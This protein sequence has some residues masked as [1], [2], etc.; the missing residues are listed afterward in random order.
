MKNYRYI[1]FLAVMALLASCREQL[2]TDDPTL[3]LRFSQDTVRF[4]TVFSST[5]GQEASA[6]LQ[7]M[8]YNDHREAIV[9]DRVWMEAGKEFSVNVDGESDLDRLTRLQ[10]NGGD[11]LF[12]FVRVG[13]A[14]QGQDGPLWHSDALHMHLSTGITQ[15]LYMEA[16]GQDVI[17]IRSTKGRS[18]FASYRFAADKPYLIYDTMVVGNLTIDA[19]AQIYMHNGA[20]VYVTGDL[21]ANGTMEE[22]IVFA[23]DRLDRLFDSVPYRFAS[24]G[25]DG[26][27]LVADHQARYD[28]KY[29]DILSGNVGL[30]CYSEQTD[31]LPQLRMEGCRIHN[32]AAYG[33]VLLNVDA[34]VVNS[35]I[36]N[37]RS[38]C[39][40][41]Q[42]GEHRFVH[43]TVAS[44]YGNTN[45]RIH[46]EWKDESAAVYINNLP[47]TAPQTITGFENCII[48]G[49]LS[50][51]VV[52]A[53][54]FDRYYPAVWRGNYLK[55]DTLRIP[56]ASANVYWQESDTVEVFRNT[57]YK[58][59]QYQYYDF[60]LDSVSPAIGIGDPQVALSYP[61]DRVGM[62]RSERVDAGC[63]QYSE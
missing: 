13:I 32:H 62:P 45:I 52:V 34:E 39:V 5:A 6:T 33:L 53:T 22:P 10:I 14:T 59:K 16:C 44:Y 47:K 36:S 2:V 9:I 50:N 31:Q 58:Y 42:G 24:G 48:T 18:D 51:Q 1:L 55:T 43:S 60:R 35:E 57:Y 15:T 20:S 8:V 27:Y 26:I 46:S 4:D 49:Y 11:S 25:W 61:T 54:P 7:V 40:Y 38:Y 41:C 17:R 3:L 56:H 23:G 29:V 12:V 37:C 28:L 30:Y 63:Y 21:E 19:G